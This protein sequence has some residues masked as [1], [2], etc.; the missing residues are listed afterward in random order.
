M[1]DIFGM[2]LKG[3]LKDIQFLNCYSIS[4]AKKILNLLSSNQ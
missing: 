1:V 3:Q 2:T 4:E